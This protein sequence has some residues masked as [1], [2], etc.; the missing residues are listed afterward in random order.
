MIDSK[1]LR[2]WGC[3]PQGEKKKPRNKDPRVEIDCQPVD[4]FGNPMKRVY[5]V[6]E[7]MLR[8]VVGDHYMYGLA[9]GAGGALGFYAGKKAAALE[10][11][12]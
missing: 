5:A 6:G 3:I 4:Q 2:V 1:D 11:W 12:S 7:V 9:T 10:A 8:D